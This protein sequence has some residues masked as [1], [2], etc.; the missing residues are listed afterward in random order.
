[1]NKKYEQN[2]DGQIG[3]SYLEQLNRALKYYYNFYNEFVSDDY[4]THSKEKIHYVVE[5]EFLNVLHINTCISSCNDNDAGNLL[6]GHDLISKALDEIDDQKPTIAI[7]HHNF[8]VLSR[9]EQEK[10]EIL[11]KKYNISLYL[12]GHAHERESELILKYNQLERLYSFTCGTLMSLD[13]K[14]KYIDTVFFEGELDLKLRNGRISSFKWDL[15]NEWH[16]DMDFGLVQGIKQNYRTF[17]SDSIDM[18]NP[19][20]LSIKKHNATGVY[21]QI[22]THQSLEREKAF[23]NL[24]EN[25]ENSLSIYGIGIS[26]VSK[27]TELLDRILQNQGI[28]R[29][30]MVDPNVFKKESCI[31]NCK[32]NE[33]NFCVFSE[34]IDQYIRSEYYE[35]ICKSFE[36]ALNYKKKANEYGWNFEFRVLKSFIPISINIINEN[37]K[38]AALIIEYNMPFTNKRLLIQANN[39]GKD[40]DYFQ[41]LC[42]VFREIWEKAVEIRDNDN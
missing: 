37:E 39:G 26:S 16:E 1:M 10:L 4:I 42:N 3:R 5:T 29:L 23:L 40:A 15:A 30:C 36:R 19:V 21:S 41:Q 35:D 13:G 7:A 14:N 34:H 22:V 33:T 27:K 24:N 11:L 38:N 31:E 12:C 25:A 9:S 32:L 2:Q 8:G 17:L 20:N 18:Q 28:V 6:I